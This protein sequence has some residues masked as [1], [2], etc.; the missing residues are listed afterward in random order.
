M[1]RAIAEQQRGGLRWIGHPWREQKN[2]LH[3]R[4]QRRG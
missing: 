4:Q 2:A 3:N 1:E